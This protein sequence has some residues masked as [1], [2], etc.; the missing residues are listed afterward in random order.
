MS[1]LLG[2]WGQNPKYFQKSGLRAP[3]THFHTVRSVVRQGRVAALHP[4][5]AEFQNGTN[6]PRYSYKFFPNSLVLQVLAP[7]YNLRLKVE[8]C[9]PPAD[10]I[11]CMLTAPATDLLPLQVCP[12]SRC[13]YISSPIKMNYLLRSN[14]FRQ[15]VFIQDKKLVL[16]PVSLCQQV[17]FLSERV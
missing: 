5:R 17:I 8:Q 14:C 12:S 10:R 13:T 3:L 11:G 4:D 16:Q 1:Q 7:Y 2:R 15:T 6:L 9:Q